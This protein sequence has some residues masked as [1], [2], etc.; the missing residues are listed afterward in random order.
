VTKSFVQKFN[1]PIIESKF[2]YNIVRIGNAKESCNKAINLELQSGVSNFLINVNATVML[3]SI[4]YSLNRIPISQYSRQLS[5]FVLADPEF[6]KPAATIPEVDMLI[7]VEYYDRI[8]T[9]EP[10]K[11]IDTVCLQSTHF[12]WTVSSAIHDNFAAP[13]CVKF[14]E[15]S[16]CGL[17]TESIDAIERIE[18]QLKSFWEIEEVNRIK[19]ASRN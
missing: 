5:E 7:G 10:R 15:S 11:W 18:Q 4:S 6:Y 2:V 17:A 1:L 3:S 16:Y 14:N 19:P 12:G 13:I 8:M 9:D